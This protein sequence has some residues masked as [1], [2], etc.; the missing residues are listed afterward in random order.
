M[1]TID[2]FSGEYAFLS[3]F[4]PS[5]IKIDGRSY[6]TVEHA[7]QAFKTLDEIWHERIRN[8]DTPGRAKRLGRACPMR[9]DWEQEKV[10]AMRY[11]LYLKFSEPTLK[12]KLASTSPSILIEGNTWGDTFWGTCRGQGLNKLGSLLME[13]R[14]A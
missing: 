11:F 5:V 6:A 2:R 8:A 7:Y 13:L 1:K 14:D 10:N 4:Y 3:N 12:E 9:N